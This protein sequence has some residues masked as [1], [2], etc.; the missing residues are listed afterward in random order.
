MESGSGIISRKR[1]RPFGHRLSD[2]TKNKIRCKRLGTHHSKETRDKISKSLSRYFKK[3][4]SLSDSM[5]YEY[6]YVSEEAVEWVEVNKDTIDDVDN[7]VAEKKLLRPN[8][9][10]LCIG[11]DIE[12][13]FGHNTT[14]EFLLMLK[15]KIQLLNDSDIL[16][17]F[18]SLVGV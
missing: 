2:E 17:E 13:F 5:L 18:N 15:E 9:I 3:K 11:S 14:P 6:N 16:K 4:D 10:E 8:Q 1:G 12:Y 7:V